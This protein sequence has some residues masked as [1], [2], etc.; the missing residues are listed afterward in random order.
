DALFSPIIGWLIL[1]MTVMQT[2][3]MFR[4]DSFG[5]V[6]H[7][8]VFAWTSGLL[9]GVTTMFANAASPIMSI[10]FL[11][12]ALPKLEFVGTSAWFFFVINVFKVPFSIWLGL[13]HGSTLLFNLVLVPAI[14]VGLACGGWL[15]RHVPQ[16]LFD[17]F[18]LA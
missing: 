14:V 10:Y 16:R 17:G 7:T 11:S 4:P 12:I 1:V 6:P 15:M 18:M 13:I 8:H 9:A 2:V 5:T 3:R